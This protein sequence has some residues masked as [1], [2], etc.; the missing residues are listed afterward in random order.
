MKGGLVG[1]FGGG[2]VWGVWGGGG[3]GGCERGGVER[4][5][6]TDTAVVRSIPIGN[7]RADKTLL[8]E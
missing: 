5:C 8:V 6:G 3:N 2:V 7:Q 1:V 4:I